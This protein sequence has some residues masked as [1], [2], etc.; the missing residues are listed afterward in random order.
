[1]NQF[2]QQLHAVAQHTPMS[3]IITPQGDDRLSVI[4]M[5]KPKGEAANK[6]GLSQPITCLGTPAELDAELPAKLL[7]YAARVND[8]RASFNLPL[9]D[10]DAE[11]KKAEARERKAAEKKA[12]EEAE[13][14]AK[15]EA[16]QK[17][18]DAAAAR[19]A[20]KAGDAPPATE[21]GAGGTPAAATET[22]AQERARLV[23]E[24]RT[25]LAKHG[26]KLKREMFL[27]KVKGGRRYERLFA[28]FRELLD[29]AAQDDLPLGEAI[30]PKVTLPGSTATADSSTDDSAAQAK[31]DAESSS[32]PPVSMPAAADPPPVQAKPEPTPIAVDMAGNVLP[33]MQRRAEVGDA[34]TLEGHPEPLAVFAV[35]PNAGHTEDRYIFRAWPLHDGEWNALDAWLYTEPKVGETIEI[36]GKPRR[37]LLIENGAVMTIPVAARP[38]TQASTI[39][40]AEV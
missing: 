19:K 34:V 12:E 2:F 1:M 24:A 33:G 29:A 26:K 38:A 35:S 37:V 22:E 18:K 28:S 8:V 11:K 23:E 32:S 16:A 39:A 21:A 15:A 14:K 9:N 36:N 25:L 13:A 5:P 27:K 17:R 4:I 40:T 7:E 10:V 30:A 31:D 20:A 3:L 6:K